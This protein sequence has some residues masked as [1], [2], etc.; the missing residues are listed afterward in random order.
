[1][2]VRFGAQH[3]SERLDGEFEIVESELMVPKALSHD[4]SSL[5]PRRRTGARG[6]AA[7]ISAIHRGGVDDQIA[8]E[9]R[10][11]A[12][13]NRVRRE[14]GPGGDAFD[15]AAGVAEATRLRRRQSHGFNMGAWG[16]KST[17]GTSQV[18]GVDFVEPAGHPWPVMCNH[19]AQAFAPKY[20][21][22]NAGPL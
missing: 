21:R 16:R 1:M 18:R 11:D 14:L 13:P 12:A 17:W 7:A 8:G 6:A 5:K 10:P 22:S 2:V 3:A 4:V 9:D 15:E 19:P 20:T